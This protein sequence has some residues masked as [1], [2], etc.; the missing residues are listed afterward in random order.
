MLLFIFFIV[1]PGVDA[2]QHF[3]MRPDSCQF[4]AE[5]LNYD[6]W[7]SA[8]KGRHVIFSM[9]STVLIGQIAKEGFTASGAESQA[10]GAGVTLAFG[11]AKE[12]S[13]AQH[14][15]NIFSYK[16]LLADVAGIILGIILLGIN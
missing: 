7:I 14:P 3:T 11:L 6:R 12:I 15:D 2:G 4:S 8:D 1:Q 16:D 5:S 9:I 10:V 13:D